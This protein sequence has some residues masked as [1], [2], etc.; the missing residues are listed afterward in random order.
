MEECICEILEE[1]HF[2]KSMPSEKMPDLWQ[3][4]YKVTFL[5]VP[6]YVKIQVRGGRAVLIS[7]KPDESER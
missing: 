4:V 2:Y 3:D 1:R 7:Y 5:G 6:L